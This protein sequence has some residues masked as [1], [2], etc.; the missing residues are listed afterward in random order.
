M[1]FTK[2]GPKELKQH[3]RG[4]FG[5]AFLACAV[6]SSN[7]SSPGAIKPLIS[8]VSKRTHADHVPSMRGCWHRIL[9]VLRQRSHWIWAQIEQAWTGDLPVSDLDILI[10][11][12]CIILYRQFL[13]NRCCESAYDVQ[14]LSV[15]LSYH[16]NHAIFVLRKSWSPAER[17]PYSEAV[18]LLQVILRFFEAVSALPGGEGAQARSK[19]GRVFDWAKGR[20]WRSLS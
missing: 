8:D 16:L 15:I 5:I 14:W 10:I 1:S 19:V 11:M 18:L 20:S 2:C 3:L 7:Q 12:Y 6:L 17:S 4:A 13:K 9:R